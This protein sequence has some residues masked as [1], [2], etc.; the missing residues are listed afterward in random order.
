[1]FG[2]Y[3]EADIHEKN[4]E[5]FCIKSEMTVIV[6]RITDNNWGNNG[7]LLQPQLFP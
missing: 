3:P 2:P 4:L 7:F 6:L 1:M 5:I